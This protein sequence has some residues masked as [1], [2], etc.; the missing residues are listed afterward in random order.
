MDHSIN[1]DGATV[2]YIALYMGY[3]GL[4]RGYVRLYRGYIGNSRVSH[5]LNTD[6]VPRSS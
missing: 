5:R 6:G 1:C 4:Y 3:I 2:E